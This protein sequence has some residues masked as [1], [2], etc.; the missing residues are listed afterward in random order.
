MNQTSAV[1]QYKTNSQ[2]HAMCLVQEVLLTWGTPS[3]QKVVSIGNYPSTWPVHKHHQAPTNSLNINWENL[4]RETILHTENICNLIHKVFC[5]SAV[6]LV[7][8]ASNMNG[9]QAM[10][11]FS[12]FTSDIITQGPAPI[13][14]EKKAT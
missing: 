6:Y 7:Q 9:F 3:H 11:S 13:P 2:Y 12:Q 5:S 4:Q 1:K 10:I 14:M 8:Q